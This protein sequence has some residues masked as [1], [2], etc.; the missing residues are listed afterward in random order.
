MGSYG[1][2][3]RRLAYGR[4]DRDLHGRGPDSSRVP[5]GPAGAALPAHE[6][7][8]TPGHQERQHTAGARRTG[9]AQ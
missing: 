3:G 5:R 8:Y 2:L 7:R 1:V 6:P 4:S 9:Q